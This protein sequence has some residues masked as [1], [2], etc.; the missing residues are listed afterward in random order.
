VSRSKGSSFDVFCR[1]A[2][3]FLDAARV[4]Y[5]VIGGLAVVAVGEPRTTGDVD[6]I[7]YAPRERMIALVDDAA[8]AGF[9]ASADVERTRLDETGTLRFRKGSFQLDVIGASL[10][11]EDEALARAMKKKLFGRTVSLPTP[12]DLLLLKVLAGRDKDMLDA[13]GI[14]R[15]HGSRLDVKYVE[16]HLR[17]LCELAE[18]MAAWRRLEDVV[19]KGGL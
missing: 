2:F 3:D 14:V 18:D 13:V 16:R 6:V 8:R 7:V 5:L 9:E 19:K 11:F 10:P 15:R 4:R 17:E 1:E 12:E